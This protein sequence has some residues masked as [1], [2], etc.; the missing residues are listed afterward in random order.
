M[1]GGKGGGGGGM[2][3]IV[4]EAA[5]YGVCCPAQIRPIHTVISLVYAVYNLCTQPHGM[6]LRHTCM[7]TP[8]ITLM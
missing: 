1:T 2:T 4:G 6:H 5:N 8:G 7:T 3:C